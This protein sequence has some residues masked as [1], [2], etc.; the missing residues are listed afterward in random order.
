MAAA[1]VAGTRRR[2][3]DLGLRRVCLLSLGFFLFFLSL[4]LSLSDFQET[5]FS[6]PE[7][8]DP[9][10]DLDLSVDFDLDVDLER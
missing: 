6:E 5:R 4:F 8:E 1:T 10:R 2:C 9:D 7:R 3:L